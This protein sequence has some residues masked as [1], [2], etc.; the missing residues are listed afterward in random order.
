MAAKE[1]VL[2]EHYDAWITLTEAYL[3]KCPNCKSEGV[4]YYDNRDYGEIEKI[5]PECKHEFIVVP[6]ENLNP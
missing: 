6:N 1:K 3:F 2:A 4:V 5:C